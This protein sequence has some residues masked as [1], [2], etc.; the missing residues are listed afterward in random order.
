LTILHDYLAIL[1]GLQLKQRMEE[2]SYCLYIP[3]GLTGQAY[4]SM[5]TKGDVLV[6]TLF[7]ANIM[8]TTRAR[9]SCFRGHSMCYTITFGP[10]QMAHN[11]CWHGA[12]KIPALFMCTSTTWL[13]PHLQSFD[14]G[15]LSPSTPRNL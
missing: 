10:T 9:C 3:G 8:A 5:D 14:Q 13:C 4:L 15:C 11:V 1:V 7:S 2:G 12:I 6:G